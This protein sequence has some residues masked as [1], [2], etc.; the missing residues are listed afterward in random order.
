MQPRWC[1]GLDEVEAKELESEYKKSILIRERLEV[2]LEQ[3]VEKSLKE[4]RDVVRHGGNVNLPEYYADELAKQRT[5]I[6]VI[7]LIK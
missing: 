6:E 4:M 1:R 2:L 5:L 3:E 7:K